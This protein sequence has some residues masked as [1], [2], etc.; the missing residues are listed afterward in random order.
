MRMQHGLRQHGAMI[1]PWWKP[2]NGD[3]RALA[4]RGG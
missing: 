2:G 3:E 4:K 1:L